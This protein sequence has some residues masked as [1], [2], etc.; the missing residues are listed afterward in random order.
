MGTSVLKAITEGGSRRS[1]RRSS[2]LDVEA[3][4]VETEQER[5]ARE[6]EDMRRAAET[7]LRSF[8]ELLKKRSREKD[9]DKGTFW[10]R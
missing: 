5:A 9:I 8:D 4:R 1:R 6:T 7:D 10:D 3:E 2:V